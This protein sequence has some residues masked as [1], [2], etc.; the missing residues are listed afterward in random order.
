MFGNGSDGS[1]TVTSGNSYS[2]G[3]AKKHQFTTLDVQAG[4]VLQPAVSTGAVLYICATDSITING[5]INT[6][7]FMQNGN[8]TWSYSVDGVTYYSPGTAASGA[9]GA[10]VYGG[11]GGAASSTGY[12]GGGAGGGAYGSYNDVSVRGGHGADGG[13]TAGTGGAAYSDTWPSG[14]NMWTLGVNNGGLYS[15]GGSGTARGDGYSGTSSAAGGA[16]GN[17]WGNNG[18]NG[19]VSG[20]RAGAGGGGGAGGL[21]GISGVHVVLSSPVIT[22]GGTI[23]TSGTAGGNG[24]NGGSSGSVG[25]S[26]GYNGSGGGGGGGGNGGNLI[27]KYRDTYTNTG[28]VTLSGGAGGAG[29][30]GYS[31]GSAGTSGTAGVLSLSQQLVQTKG[32]TGYANIIVPIADS[33]VGSIT[34]GYG[35]FGFGAIFGA[36]VSAS[37]LEVQNRLQTGYANIRAQTTRTQTGSATIAASSVRDQTGYSRIQTNS[38]V[39]QTGSATVQALVNR[40]QLGYANILYTFE[41]DQL[42]YASIYHTGSKDISGHAYIYNSQT[43]PGE[44][45]DAD[46]NVYIKDI[47]QASQGLSE[48]NRAIDGIYIKEYNE[49]GL[50]TESNID[51]N[52]VY[53]VG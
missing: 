48:A 46:G 23:I 9:G 16:G 34:G 53:R 38:L 40:N 35:T 25:G 30:T 42:G 14:A 7:G 37:G 26:I 1:L 52:G 45:T 43:L 8:N 13:A 4:G 5:T 41:R 6:A 17:A 36:E 11:I 28:T 31:A 12:G 33:P 27:V 24:G 44:F 50:L 51:N 47:R 20:V 21:A 15:S 18:A 19:S 10:N 49:S 32:Q 39:T 3:L 2:L 29:G 22:I